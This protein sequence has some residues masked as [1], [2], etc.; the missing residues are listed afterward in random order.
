MRDRRGE[1]SFNAE[2][3]DTHDRL[4]GWADWHRNMRGAGGSGMNSIAR[5]MK[6]GADGAGASDAP[7]QMPGHIECIDKAVASL[8]Q[9][10]KTILTAYYLREEP[11]E[12]IAH[13]LKTSVDN[14]KYH[15]RLGRM[16]VHGFVK[17]WYHGRKVEADE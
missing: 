17:G 16:S 15:L 8:E 11:F 1:N 10:K 3:R 7:V 12:A 14:V 13:D 4:I 5:L 6:Y 2:A 9:I